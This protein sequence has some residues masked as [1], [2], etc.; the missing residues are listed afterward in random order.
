ML[1]HCNNG[2]KKAPQCYVIRTLSVRL[3]LGN[4]Y[5]LVPTYLN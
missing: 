5:L 4:V 2:L 3:K 1:V